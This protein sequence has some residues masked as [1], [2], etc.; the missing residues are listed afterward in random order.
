MVA[1]Y[2]PLEKLAILYTTDEIDAQEIANEVASFAPDGEPIVAQLGPV[3]GNYLG[4]GTL[5]LG[6]I[7]AEDS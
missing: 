5:G 1:E 4:P 2:A 3:V 7:R 6:L